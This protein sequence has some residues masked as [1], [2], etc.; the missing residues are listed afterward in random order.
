MY[1]DRLKLIATIASIC[2]KVIAFQKKWC[3]NNQRND[4]SAQIRFKAFR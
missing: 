1:F 4:F 2:K 3:A